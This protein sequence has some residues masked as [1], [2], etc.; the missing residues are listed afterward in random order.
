MNGADVLIISVTHIRNT[1]N[2]IKKHNT[3]IVS[4]DV[5]YGTNIEN[6]QAWYNENEKNSDSYNGELITTCLTREY[7]FSTGKSIWCNDG[8]HDA[9]ADLNS[10]DELR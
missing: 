3:L 9:A 7:S 2:S 5:W 10:G 8:K 1:A 4:T 6:L